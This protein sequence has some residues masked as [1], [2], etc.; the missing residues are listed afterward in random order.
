MLMQLD[1]G[2]L[3]GSIQLHRNI[4]VVGTYIGVFKKLFNILNQL[5]RWRNIKLTKNDS[6]MSPI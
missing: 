2:N 3:S 6:E 4:V 1:P 5:S